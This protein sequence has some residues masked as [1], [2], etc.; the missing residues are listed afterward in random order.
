MGAMIEVR[1]LVKRF[2]PLTAV[3]DVSFSVA[4]GEVLGVL[5]PNGAGK[6][7][8]MKMVTGFLTPTSGSIT[9]CGHD[10]ARAPLAAKR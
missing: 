9:V 1:N 8:T 10:V 7:T 2:G 6:S 5:G 3:D 4:R